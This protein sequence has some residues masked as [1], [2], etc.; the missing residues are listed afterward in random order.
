MAF[1]FFFK[2]ASFVWALSRIFFLRSE[3]IQHCKKFRNYEEPFASVSIYLV[4]SMF[5]NRK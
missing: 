3:H 5:L 2:D 4:L 1:N